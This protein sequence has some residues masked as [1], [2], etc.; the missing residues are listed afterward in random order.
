M[1]NTVKAGLISIVATAAPVTAIAQDFEDYGDEAAEMEAPKKRAVR[2]IVKGTYAKTNVGGAMFLGVHADWVQPGVY[3][4]IS[5]GQDFYDQENLSMAWELMFSQGIHNGAPY[6]EQ[7]GVCAQL[8]NCIQGDIQT[9]TIA[10]LYEVSFY[11]TR[12]LGVGFR[13][14]GGLSFLPLL[15]DKGEFEEKVVNDWE[16]YRPA[17]HDGA[18]PVVVAGPTLEYYTKLSHFSVGVDVD[19]IYIV[20]FDPGLAASGSVK[21][22]F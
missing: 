13:A 22:T 14:G 10:G 19:G 4:S 9:F 5:V 6:E 15:M 7:V 18:L 12:R 20:G 2:E 1:T 21:Y 17:Y 8:T 11:P 16:G 3:S